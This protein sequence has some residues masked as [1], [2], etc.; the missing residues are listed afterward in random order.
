M[1]FGTPRELWGC[2]R[3]LLYTL[4]G[5]KLGSFNNQEEV[6]RVNKTL[7]IDGSFSSDVRQLSSEVV[8]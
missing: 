1:E 6:I 8:L 7:I 4:V 2:K 5:L 3:L